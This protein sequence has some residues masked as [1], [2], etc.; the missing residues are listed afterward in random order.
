MDRLRRAALLAVL[1]II[2]A[3]GP[4]QAATPEDRAVAVAAASPAPESEKAAIALDAAPLTSGPR[5]YLQLLAEAL[6]EQPPQDDVRRAIAA[7]ASDY[8]LDPALIEA[9]A[10]KESRFQHKAR[11]RRGA[12]GVM[13]LLPSTARGLGVNP[14]DMAQNVRGGALYLRQM[15]G[16]FG[17]DVKLALAAYNAGPGAVRR[18]G[19]VP[20]YAETQNYV[21]AIL[22]RMALTTAVSGR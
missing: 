6:A 14:F 16:Q 9:V 20:P 17:G 4:V 5:P 15:L 19:G 2:C 12:V 8:A 13:Q 22:G 21:T 1:T 18:H 3:T 10:W 7:A 11:S